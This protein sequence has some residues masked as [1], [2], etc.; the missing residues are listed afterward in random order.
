[1]LGWVFGPTLER[2]ESLATAGNFEDLFLTSKAFNPLSI[3]S[4]N[5]EPLP[6]KERLGKPVSGTG[7]F[8]LPPPPPASWPHLSPPEFQPQELRGWEK[9]GGGWLCSFPTET[10]A[11]GGGGSLI[12]MSKNPILQYLFNQKERPCTI[13]ASTPYLGVIVHI[14]NQRSGMG[15]DQPEG[16]YHGAPPAEHQPCLRPDRDVLKIPWQLLVGGISRSSPHTF[17]C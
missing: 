1:M 14:F 9:V 7:N 13:S 15:T 2:R 8:Q 4:L 17:R 16:I 10:A 12:H 11:G 3:Q 5:L 6:F